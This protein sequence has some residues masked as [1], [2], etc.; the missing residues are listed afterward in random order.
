VTSTHAGAAPT[1]ASAKPT[2]PSS[3]VYFANRNADAARKM[4]RLLGRFVAG[5]LALPDARRVVPGYQHRLD[6]RK[7]R[8]R[9]AWLREHGV[10]AVAR[11]AP[12]KSL[13]R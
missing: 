7:R 2:I 12:L 11:F 1:S 8:D 4:A 3:F 5:P 10:G 9:A 6:A 13:A